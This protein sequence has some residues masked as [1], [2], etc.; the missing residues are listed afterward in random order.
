[1]KCERIRVTSVFF[2]GFCV[3][4]HLNF[5]FVQC[6]SLLTVHI[7]VRV[8]H[9]LNHPFW[10]FVFIHTSQCVSFSV[11]DWCLFNYI[12]SLRVKTWFK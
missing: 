10:R 2:L 11:C 6:I 12:F 8:A 9:N 5:D 4:E 3:A 7:H 1:M